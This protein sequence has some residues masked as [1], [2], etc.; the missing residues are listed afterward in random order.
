MNETPRPEA[1]REIATTRDGIDIT[2]GYTGPLLEPYD[3]VLRNRGGDLQI[4]EQ[5]FS[6][7]EVK[8]TVS[9][10]QLAVT[11]CE[12][13]VDAGGDRPVDEEAAEFLREQLHRIGWD[14]ITTKMLMGVFFGFAVAEIIYKPDGNRIVID[15]IKVRNTRRFRYGK[16]GDLRLLT[17]QNM[18][19]GIP[20]E[21]PY[22]WNFSCGAYND[23]EPYGLGLAHWLYW[24][25]LFKRNGI[26]FWLI[27]LEKFGMPTTV[28]KYDATATAAEKI[29]LLQ[30]AQA[31]QTDSGMIMPKEMELDL[32]EAARSGTADYEKLQDK[33]D[34]T[35]QKVVLGQTASTQGTPG[36]L[37][38]DNLQADVRKDIIK[39]DADLV[40]ESFNIGPVRW[41]I[42]WNFPGAAMPRVSRVTQEPEDLD[43][44]ADRDEKISQLGFRPTLKHI[45]DVYGGDWV[46]SKPPAPNPADALTPSAISD[47]SFA[48]AGRTV[49]DL[50]QRHHAAAF[51]DAALAD[52]AVLMAQQLNRAL[53]PVGGQWVDQVRNLVNAADSLDSLYDQILA[54]APE[55]DL[56]AFAQAKADAL[57]AAT[58]AG[59]Y[60]LLPGDGEA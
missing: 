51:A 60:D 15:A 49:M 19:E 1:N 27:F 24:P 54:L 53:A 4:Y 32:L 58:L 18:H 16:E 33:M 52:P 37:G 20:A 21:A 57:T 3:S 7:P 30:A 28:G 31:I 13:Q 43:A 46:E 12:W 34:A 48:Q 47:A 38:N 9:Q 59:R 36:K 17:M 11:Q 22:F 56:E 45:Q 42:E 55:M 6:D 8:S 40:C 10:R 41:L 26:K 14:N 44:R 25:V 35:I 2:R 5:V 39:A 23:D 50:L 29:K